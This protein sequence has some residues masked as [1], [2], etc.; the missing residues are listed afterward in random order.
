MTLFAASRPHLRTRVCALTH[1]GERHETNT[2][3]LCGKEQVLAPYPAGSPRRALL[4]AGLFEDVP[5]S[6]TSAMAE[7]AP[8]PWDPAAF[9]PI[10]VGVGRF[11][12]R[13]IS[14]QAV[15]GCFVTAPEYPPLA[16]LIR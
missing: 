1:S 11:K 13:C 4:E 15:A 2:P 14:S 8:R 12:P 6:A 16:K 5:R 9:W 3:R 10:A 7:D